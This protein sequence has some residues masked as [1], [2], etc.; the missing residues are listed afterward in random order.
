MNQIIQ[1]K[2]ID[3]SREPYLLTSGELYSCR[4]ILTA[5]GLAQVRGG[6]VVIRQLGADETTLLLFP[7]SLSHLNRNNGKFKTGQIDCGVLSGYD[8]PDHPEE[9]F[10]YE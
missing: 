3:T 7:T 1:W 4:N 5:S 2:G 9:H 10:T 6:F 8:G